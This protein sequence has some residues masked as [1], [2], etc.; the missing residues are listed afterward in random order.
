MCSH[1]DRFSI[2]T[3]SI[4]TDFCNALDVSR[5][6]CNLSLQ[7]AWVHHVQLP[8]QAVLALCYMWWAVRVRM[9]LRNFRME[10]FCL[11]TNLKDNYNFLHFHL[12]NLDERSPPH[13][14][15]MT[16]PELKHNAA[17]VST[18]CWRVRPFLRLQAVYAGA[19]EMIND[20]E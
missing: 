14:C 18:M 7:S 20:Y 8:F 19:S 10:H 13:I 12:S 4:T 5:P 1:Q 6:V 17:R 11:W 9:C 16:S 3:Q 2:C 15:K